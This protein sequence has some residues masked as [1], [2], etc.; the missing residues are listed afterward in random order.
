[1]TCYNVVSSSQQSISITIRSLPYTSQTN[2]G[3]SSGRHRELLLY[4]IHQ[5][6]A[7]DIILVAWKGHVGQRDDLMG[8]VDVTKRAMSEGCVRKYVFSNG[9]T[10]G[11]LTV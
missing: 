10:D 7:A 8:Q 3:D 6:A 2:K 1:M 11:S 5:R 9:G 4:I